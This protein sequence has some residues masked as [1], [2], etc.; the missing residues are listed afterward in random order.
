MTENNTGDGPSE[1]PRR[2]WI[3]MISIGIGTG[4][5]GC[6]GNGGGDGD[7]GGDGGSDGGD[8]G[9]DGGDGG[10][11]DGSD[12]GGGDGG[13]NDPT[14]ITYYERAEFGQQYVDTFNGGQSEVEASFSFGGTGGEAPVYRKFIQGIRAGDAPAVV[15][16]DMIVRNDFIENG[17]LSELPDLASEIDYRDDF[18]DS[19][20]PLFIEYEGTAYSMPFWLACSNYFYNK[21]HFED[22][23][24]DPENPPKTWSEFRSAAETLSSDGSPAV[25]LNGIGGSSFL[26]LPWVW[27]GNG[28]FIN[29]DD[30]CVIDEEPGV[31]ALEFWKGLADDGLSTPP[32]QT[33]WSE[34]RNKF[35]TGEASMIFDGGGVISVVQENDAVSLQDV[36]NHP[37]PKPEGGAH[38]GMTGGNAIAISANVEDGSERMQAAKE[39]VKWVNS[40]EGMR[41]TLEAGN[42]PARK[43][44]FELDAANQED[45][46]HLLQGLSDVLA[47]ENSRMLVHPASAEAKAEYLNP[48]LQE[49]YSG[50]KSPQEALSTAAEG[51]NDN[52]LN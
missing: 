11:S 19:V 8:G 31:Q 18:Y 1:T 25:S 43:A 30:E 50:N 34:M 4:L 45:T 15:G 2:E 27:A 28:R 46:G 21:K 41:V 47:A 6:S 9:S 22:A 13:D 35:A 26:W 36:G 12:G 49:C 17:Y 10:G 51:I 40:E 20:D 7:G 29:D 52:I 33:G 14:E 32:A 44:G 39:F 23:G 16:T 5:A 37:F 48:Q 42:L 24:L 38:A 3:K